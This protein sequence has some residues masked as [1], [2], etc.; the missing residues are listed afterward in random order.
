M[1]NVM[2]V[3][4]AAGVVAG[5]G[6]GHGAGNGQGSNSVNVRQ[7]NERVI[8]N[9]LRRLGQASKADLS[10]SVNLTSN[11][12]GVIVKELEERGLIRSEGKRS[13]A[14]GQPAT[15]L[16]LNPEGA[17]SIGVKVGRR[18]VDTL[19]VDFRGHVVERRHHERDFP[20]P[21][22][23][24]A[25]ALGDIA[26][27]RDA[28]PSDAKD[29]LAGIGV[30][31]PYDMGSWRRELDIRVD[32]Y[33]V[34]NDV[35]I[36]ARLGASTGLPVFRENDGTAAAVAEMFRGC[37]RELQTFAYLFIGSAIGGGLVLN[38]EYYR[39]VTGN[40]GDIG[41]MPVGPSRLASAPR[42]THSC[43]ILLTRASINSLIRHLRANGV[44]VVLRSELERAI[45]LHPGLVAEWLDDA[46]D[47]LVMPLL[48]AA[49]LLD[50]EAIVIDADL[51]MEVR[52]DLES[53]LNRCLDEAVP[54]ARRPPP[55]RLGQVGR[56]AAALGAAILPLH[57]N[58]SPS[59]E[60]LVNQ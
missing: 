48:S 9:A 13:G 1:S 10:R 29:R 58:Y 56:Q 45:P 59:R 46:A 15:L 4:S 18:S 24:L 8:L 11:T 43:D 25:L 5:A 33:R 27:M 51:P 44:E 40:A 54:E 7:F 32:A 41:L 17:Y 50:V 16:S 37:G 6:A 47:A 20:M 22:E 55:L 21:E 19:L 28:L 38:G 39:G 36:A 52:R 14:R 34:W 53:R 3:N 30:A 31:A 35:D 12:A 2:C 60:I 49:C 26:A 57:L 42:P 23:S